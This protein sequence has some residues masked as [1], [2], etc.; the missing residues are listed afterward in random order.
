MTL[1]AI[2]G[3]EFL[4]ADDV[5]GRE[6]LNN[7]LGL[8]PDVET[9]HFKLWLASQAVLNRVLHNAEVT[10]SEFKARKVYEQACRYVQ[11]EAYPAA[12]TMLR[13]QGVVVI[14]GPPGVGKTTLAD[15]LL[16]EHLDL[17]YQA[18]L[19]RHGVKEGLKLARSGVKQVFYYDDCL[20]PTFAGE[21]QPQRLRGW[22]QALLDFIDQVRGRSDAR[23][24]LTT[25]EHVYAQALERSERLR[26]SILEDL[27]GACPP[28]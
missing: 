11:G 10:Q 27:R 13:E 12:A 22:D 9:R 26:H 18:V 15:L 19:I 21:E 7:L 1:V 16:Y 3:A 28:Q 14:A 20:G 4:R 5:M 2:I 24:I 6:S 25:R 17:G 8:H 23:L